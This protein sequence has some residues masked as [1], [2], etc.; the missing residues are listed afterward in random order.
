MPLYPHP[1]ENPLCKCKGDKLMSVLCPYGHLH[2]CHHP[3][4]CASAGCGHLYKYE[5][6][7][8]KADKLIE[9]ATA[10]M[11]AGRMPEYYIPLGRE[12]N[13]YATGTD[14]RSDFELR[15]ILLLSEIDIPVDEIAAWEYPD[16]EAALD[17][18]VELMMSKHLEAPAL[19]EPPEVLKKHLP[20]PA[21]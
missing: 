3:Y 13:A 7:P 21:E 10:K 19:P 18:A 12:E 4:D 14:A 17:Y 16:Y 9:A 1:S 2:Q 20:S 5:I 15:G 8:E 6:E 11:R